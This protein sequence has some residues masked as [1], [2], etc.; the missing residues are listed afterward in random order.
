MCCAELLHA[1]LCCA[2]L[3]AVR[4]TKWALKRLL[5]GAFELVQDQAGV[6]V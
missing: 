3:P 4:A 5:R 1:V 6:C 2:V